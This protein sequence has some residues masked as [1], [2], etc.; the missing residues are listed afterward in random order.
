MFNDIWG[1]NR[2]YIFLIYGVSPGVLSRRIEE[3]KNQ[4]VCQAASGCLVSAESSLRYLLKTVVTPRIELLCD[5]GAKY[6]ECQG[7]GLS[8]K[9][10]LGGMGS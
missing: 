5:G 8:A 1:E 3:K 6:T 7:V 2:G 4:L 10:A 9:G